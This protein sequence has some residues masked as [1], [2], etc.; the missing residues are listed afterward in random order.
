[1]SALKM[2]PISTSFSLFENKKD[3]KWQK[4]MDGP[5]FTSMDLQMLLK[6]PTRLENSIAALQSQFDESMARNYDFFIKTCIDASTITDDLES[7]T[8]NIGDLSSDLA[9]ANNLCKDL[10]L[11][12]NSTRESMAKISSAFLKQSEISDILIAPQL[13]RTCRISN[14][15]DEAL[16]VYNILEQFTRQHPNTTSLKSTLEEANNVKNEV[17]Q[18]LLNTFSGDL[19]LED[20]ISNVNLLRTAK[21]HS[22]A[23][24]RLAFIN[25]RRMALHQK[26]KHISKEDPNKYMQELT[27]NFRSALYE[28]STTYKAILASEDAEDDMTLHLVIQKEC[29]KYCKALKRSLEKVTKVDDAKEM[30]LNAFT[31]ASSFGRL[32]F[33]FSPLIENCFY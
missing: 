2:Y 25:G 6:E 13:M 5:E 16:Q 1:M 21:V 3:K 4:I 27:N 9:K 17:T 32:G 10:C 19:K 20:A 30:V 22:E 26:I 24:I 28:I 29:E 15:Y 14:L 18:S 31:F 8:K 23:E 11:L 33:D 12:A 7:C